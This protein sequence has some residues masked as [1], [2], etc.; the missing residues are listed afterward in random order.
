MK[1][2]LI[3]C[4]VPT[5]RPHFLEHTIALFEKQ[6]YPRKELIIVDEHASVGEQG[7]TSTRIAENVWYYLFFGKFSPFSIGFK[8][9]I[10]CSFASGDI[11]CHWDDDD[12]YAPNRLSL[13]VHPILEDQ[14]DVTALTMTHLLRTSDMS[15]WC[16]DTEMRNALFPHGVKAGTLM[17]LASYWKKGIMYND[18]NQGEDIQFL[19]TLSTQ[20]ERARCAQLHHPGAFLCVR[21][22][23][24]ISPE[25][26]GIEKPHWTRDEVER[27]LSEEEQSFYRSLQ[28]KS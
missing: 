28:K 12:W 2:P 4:I 21:H 17:Y 14:A 8:R 22:D 1:L 19:E 7:L 15:L 20:G 10:T 6:D 11:I 27:Y 16:P 3:S 13:Q 18:T 23:E 24:N 26:E 5:I 9:N 25:I